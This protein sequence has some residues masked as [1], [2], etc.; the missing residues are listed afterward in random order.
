EF[1]PDLEVTNQTTYSDFLI[2][3]NDATRPPDSLAGSTIDGSQWS[4]EMIVRYQPNGARLSG[5]GGIYYFE[6]NE[7]NLAPALGNEGADDTQTSL[8]IYA[9]GVASITDRISLTA[10]LRYQRDTQ[11]RSFAYQIPFPNFPRVATDFEGT[12]KAFLPR[13]ELAY[14]ITDD[15]R[16]GTLISRGTNP[17]GVVPNLFPTSPTNPRG[18]ETT[19][20]QDESVWTYELFARTELLD[21]RLRFDAN[22]FYADY[23]DFQLFTVVDDTFEQFGVVAVDIDNIDGVY[24][25]GLEAEVVFEITEKLNVFANLG[26][27]KS[28]VQESVLNTDTGQLETADREF[29]TAPPVTGYFGGTYQPIEPLSLTAQFRYVDAFASNTFANPQEAVDDVFITN[30]S[31]GYR[32]GPANVYFYVENLFDEFFVTNISFNGQFA[33]PGAPRTF[34]GGVVFEF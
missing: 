17:G 6:K 27:L 25:Y 16:I 8:G 4:N 13:V 28:R 24:T 23:S 12:Y 11:D 18:G 2:T 10:A 7:D 5:L 26:L 31:A 30:I 22:L 32:L 14:D 19:E 9:V 15:L 29:G 3:F 34:G 1:S 21:G 20:F 33:F